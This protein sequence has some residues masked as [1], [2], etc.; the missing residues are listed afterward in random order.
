MK[1]TIVLAMALIMGMAFAPMAEAAVNEVNME[2]A[3]PAKKKTTKKKD[4]KED[5]NKEDNDQTSNDQESDDQDG[6]HKH[7]DH[8]GRYACRA[9]GA[10]EE[11]HRDHESF[12]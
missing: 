8:N 6:C 5:D 9:Y 4:D 1:K 11:D 12:F 2:M 3:A 7:E 10:A